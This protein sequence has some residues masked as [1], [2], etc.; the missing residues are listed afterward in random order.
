MALL[1]VQDVRVAFGGPPL[2]DGAQF[3]IERGERVCL[4][5][6]N[7]A[8]K[9]TFLQLLAGTLLPDE[10]Q[11]VRQGGV[12]V[13]RLEQ[14]VPRD[15]DG[16]MFDI[17]AAGLGDTGRL[18]TAFHAAS[19]QVG[20]DPSETNLQTLDRLHR[21]LDA[22]DAWQLH[23]RVETVLQHLGL[24][25]DAL[26]AQASGG[27]TRQALLARA[28]VSAPDVLLLDEPTNHL[29]IDAIEWME[30]FLVDQGI[31][32]VFVTHDRAFLRRVATRIVELD[33]GRLADFGPDYDT[34]LERKEQVLHAE[35]L[36]WEDFDRRLAQEEVWIRTGIQARRTRNE[37][38]VRALESMRVERAA[39]RDRVGISRAQ[40]Q[41]AERSGRLVLEAQNIS[42]AHGSR[43]I[44]C[45][46]TTTIMRGDRVGLI[47]PNGSGK[48]TLLKLLLG[49]LTP[50][51]GSV[52][53]GTNLEIAYFDQL[54][55]QLDPEKSVVESIGD[56]TDWV[57]VGGQRR[58]V[59]GYLQ[60]FLFS[61]E[62]ARTPVRALSG[63]E[64]NRVLL[65]RL[66][67]QAFNVL[68]LDEPTNDL[69]VETLDM[70][71]ALLRDFGGT[72][73]LVSHDRAFLDA[74]VTSTL[75]FEGSGIVREY[76]G[77][78]TDWVRQRPT[79]E[80]VPA[81]TVAEKAAPPA[82]A[83]KAK[84]RKLSYKETAELET[85]PDRIAEAEA[86]REAVFAQLADPAV[87]RDG[88]R[89]VALQASLAD[90]DARIPELMARWEE[91]E[92]IA[93]A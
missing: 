15:L 23:L 49:E 51:E 84:K 68:V 70:L 77:G 79:L 38:R 39:R 88:A 16:T 37:G 48:T 61:Q 14:A 22:A 35:S 62:R 91:L 24:P 60:D 73:L 41:D 83:P 6:R 66:F 33:R 81:R 10:G 85:L 44:V 32:L 21:Q 53:H 56:G 30:R 18:L 8:G 87:L 54:R 26:I 74:V 59:H 52:R 57:T 31:T 1:S 55:E 47:G 63:G 92:T 17:V 78:Y 11:V 93:S 42:F 2:L 28:L 72:L 58:H 12:T 80:A 7:G 20:V 82:A 27:R 43:P 71:E 64:R 45:G 3:A 69:D 90:L 4:L 46:L 5:G 9:S 29:D 50:D 89:V 75:V 86:E 76:A 40:I 34:Y 19:V 67:T 25:A 13:A 36:A 65:A